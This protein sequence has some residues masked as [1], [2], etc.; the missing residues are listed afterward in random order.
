MK[1][2]LIQVDHIILVDDKTQT[3]QILHNPPPD[4]DH[5]LKRGKL[6]RGT[7]TLSTNFQPVKILADEDNDAEVGIE[8]VTNE[9]R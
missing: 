9:E 3:L 4:N 2:L 7:L 5:R 8:S 6:I 1:F